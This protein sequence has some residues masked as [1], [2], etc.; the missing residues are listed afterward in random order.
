MVA[1]PILAG[2][3]A[4]AL[5]SALP[6][7]AQPVMPVTAGGEE[8]VTASHA[9]KLPTAEEQARAKAD[10][11][12]KSVSAPVGT[13]EQIVAWLANAPPLARPGTDADTAARDDARTGPRQMHGEAGVSVGTGGYRSAYVT[14]R[15]PVGD[16]GVVGLA[17]SQTDFGRN[18][19]YGYDGYGYGGY[20]G[21]DRYGSGYG[22][23]GYGYGS[24]GGSAK[25]VALSLDMT[26]D[27][28]G[29]SEPD[30][31]A[32]GF[33][34]GD[35]YVEPVWVSRMHDGRDCEAGNDQR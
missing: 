18:G 19:G 10:T 20:Y 5:T 9:V 17:Y 29:K 24:R 22:R 35:H 2:L 27:S 34:D 6:V 23:R 33:R 21:Y 30:G 11:A 25:S 4:L 1:S 7:A 32:P 15:I 13:Q 8:V 14:T 16:K 26:G 3:A 12:A 31:C 28:T